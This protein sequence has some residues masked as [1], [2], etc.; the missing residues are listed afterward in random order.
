MND[1][2]SL[3]VYVAVGAHMYMCLWKIVIGLEHLYR[4]AL[5]LISY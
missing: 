5:L 2:V 1:T 3:G 4:L